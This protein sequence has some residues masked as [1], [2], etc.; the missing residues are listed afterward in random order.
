MYGEDA[1]A[2]TKRAPMNVVETSVFLITARIASPF[3]ISLEHVAAGA[4]ARLATSIEVGA[5][6]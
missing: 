2:A 6:L 1:D 4:I 5:R 3:A